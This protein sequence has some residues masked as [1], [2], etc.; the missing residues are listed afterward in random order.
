MLGEKGPLPGAKRLSSW[1][2]IAAFVG[3]DERTV[4]RWEDSRGLPVRRVP[5]SGKSAVFAYEEEI[6]SWIRSNDAAVPSSSPPVVPATNSVAHPGLR[7]KPVLLMSL[8]GI[9]VALLVIALA[10]QKIALFRSDDLGQAH[11]PDA[12]A[13]GL[14]RSG[15]HAWQTRSPSGLARAEKDFSEAIKRDPHYAEAYAG[16]AGVYDLEGEFTTV[17]PDRAYP[18]AAAAARHAIALD[19]RLADAHAALAFADFYWSRDVEAARREFRASLALDPRSATAHHWYA[20][21]LMAT[22]DIRQALLEIGKA[23]SLDFESAAI[24]ADKGLILFYAGKTGQAVEL[25]TQLEEDQ[26]AFASPHRYLAT[27]WLAKGADTAFLHELRLKARSLHDPLELEMAD[28]GARGLANGG[29]VGMLQHILDAQLKFYTANKLPAYAIADTYADLG[30]RENAFKYLEISVARHEAD[31][32]GL[33]IDQ[34]FLRLRSDPR[35]VRLLADVGLA[36][37]ELP[38]NA[39]AP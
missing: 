30:D 7:L 39:L 27:I 23:E 28:A 34:S 38:P 4:K 3:R 6:E 35:F 8:A 24:P 17:Q 5:G 18:A 9:A 2:E 20:T 12:L 29:H 13:A 37:G 19:S 22:G 25:L 15:L 33:K 11:R 16:L 1:K 14:Y 31:N 26:P 32:I 21:F 36:P 10:W